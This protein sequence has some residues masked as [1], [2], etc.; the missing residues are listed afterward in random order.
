M[1]EAAR[2][3]ALRMI[4]YGLYLLG[5]RRADVRGP[6]DLHAYVVSW[7]TQTSFKPP[8]VVVGVGKESH[9]NGLVKE[10]RVF[11]LNVL[12]ADQKDL[13]KR[14]FK[15]IERTDGHLGGTP[16]VRGPLTGC[17]LFTELPASIECE[18]AHVYD[19]ENDH[20]V[21]VGKVVGVEH[22]R[23]AKPLTTSETGW[24]YAG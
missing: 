24:A 22:R 10:S 7:V 15:E 23:D 4:P 9:A 16:I 5:C 1:D 21:V 18:V 20:S 12:G 2:K 3:K 8:M 11:S 6:E 19:G 13:A 17:P 14:F